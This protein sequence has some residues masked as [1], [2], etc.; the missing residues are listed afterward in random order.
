MGN[1][2]VIVLDGFGIGQMPDVPDVRPLDV[3]ANTCKHIFE[4]VPDLVLPN[5]QKLGL[6]N[7]LGM[8]FNGLRFSENATYGR[9]ALMHYGADTFYGHQEIMGTKPCKPT[10]EMIQPYLEPIARELSNNGFTTRFHGVGDGKG[11][12]VVDDAV[13]VADNVECDPGQAC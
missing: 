12:L 5:L 9:C 13:T 1:F 4:A 8:E 10:A 3:G 6:A 7:A 11:L 2:A